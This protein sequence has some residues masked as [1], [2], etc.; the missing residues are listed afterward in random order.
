M[1]ICIIR[2]AVKCKKQ[3]V[4]SLVRDCCMSAGCGLQLNIIENVPN[5]IT[6]MLTLGWYPVSFSYMNKRH[7]YCIAGI[8]N[9]LYLT[10]P[11]S[12]T[13]DGK[14]GSSFFYSSDIFFCWYHQSCKQWSSWLRGPHTPKL[15]HHLIKSIHIQ[16]TGSAFVWRP[17]TADPNCECILMQWHDG[18]ERKFKKRLCVCLFVTLWRCCNKSVTRLVRTALSVPA[19]LL[20]DWQ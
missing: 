20:C 11:D 16:L 8:F 2:S 9:F 13:L 3:H 7:S 12:G 19:Q 4:D 15:N 10:Q 5:T 17:R 18:W 1:V 6:P 14:F